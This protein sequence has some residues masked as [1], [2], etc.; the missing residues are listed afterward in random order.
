MTTETEKTTMENNQ[1]YSE[2]SSVEKSRKNPKDKAQKIAELNAKIKRIENSKNEQIKK[3]EAQRQRMENEKKSAWRGKLT[4]IKILFGA[5][6]VNLF[7]QSPEKRNEMI[8]E[9]KEYITSERE[10]E[11]ID[12]FNENY[13]EMKQYSKQKGKSQKRLKEKM[14]IEN[15]PMGE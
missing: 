6:M 4:H 2:N 1:S 8:R 13:D 12:Y 11:H 9:L 10:H 14:A 3:L 7:D 5:Y 15:E